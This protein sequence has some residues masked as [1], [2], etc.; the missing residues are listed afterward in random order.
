MK[1]ITEKFNDRLSISQMIEQENMSANLDESL[2][3]VFN[4]VKSKFKQVWQWVRGLVVKIGTY[5]LP[6][7]NDSEIQP[8]ITPM[9][10]G[11]AYREGLAKDD[12]TFI[13]NSKDAAKISGLRTNPK[14]ALGLLGGNSKN[15]TFKYWAEQY[16][17]FEGSEN[18]KANVNEVKMH[19]EDPEA[20]WNIIVDDAELR[21][22]ITRHIKKAG[23]ARL[24]IWGAP[25]IGKTAILNAVVDSFKKAGNDYNLI[26]KT[27]SNE[28]PDNFMLPKYVEVGEG[29]VKAEDVPKTWLP[30]YH[31]TGDPAKDAALDASLGKGMLFIDEL[32]R[33]TQQVLNVCLPLIN[34]GQFNGWQMGSGWCIVC[35]SNRPEDEDSGQA[36][37]G[38]AMLNRFAHVYYEPTVHTWRKWADKQGFMSPLLLQW[39][40]LPETENMS[41]GKYYYMDPNEDIQNASSTALMCTPRAWTNAMR[42]LAEY[43]HTGDLQ[44]F[45]IFD[46]P[47][48]IIGRVLN[49]YVPMSAVDSFIAFLSV[50]HSIG[51]FD[52]VTRDIW[53]NGGKNVKISAKDLVKISLPLAQLIITSHADKLPT[54]KEF[55][56]L[57]VWLKDQKNDQLASYVLD[58]FKSTF[59]GDIKDTTTKDKIFVLHKIADYIKEQPDYE[60]MKSLYDA[61]FKPFFDRWNVDWESA[62][63]YS[64]GLQIAGEAYGETFRNA[65]VDGQEALG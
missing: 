24:L 27:L 22:E 29:N 35:A 25:G 46:I 16:G 41:G 34:E 13:Y 58:I 26:V 17:V 65:I 61:V 64:K 55:E 45:T 9:T 51:D 59:M 10:A 19:T 36:P 40:S 53:Q 1:N 31:P 62:P 14:D 11:V 23:L 2:K 57:S 48:N 5:V 39:L 32:S 44:G 28:T 47:T 50:I 37:L 21:D 15:D 4:V 18:H 56:N 49:K 3:D 43:S 7:S 8:A 38:N 6:V 63:D 54:D 33:A 12:H 30:V 52:R 60:Q 20:K 42:D